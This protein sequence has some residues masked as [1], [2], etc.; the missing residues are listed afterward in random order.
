[1]SAIVESVVGLLSARSA[2]AREQMQ[3]VRGWIASCVAAMH[4]VNAARAAADDVRQAKMQECDTTIAA[5]PAELA[6]LADSVRDRDHARVSAIVDDLNASAGDA[7]AKLLDKTA[8]PDMTKEIDRFQRAAADLAGLDRASSFR[9][10]AWQ[11]AKL[12]LITIPVVSAYL[13]G[14]YFRLRDRVDLQLETLSSPLLAYDASGGGYAMRPDW[15]KRFFDEF[16][17][18][19]FGRDNAMPADWKTVQL[20]FMFRNPRHGAPLMI[21]TI[22]ATSTYHASPFPWQRVDDTPNV[23][24]KRDR[25]NIVLADESGV[26]APVNVRANISAA[27][28]T[29]DQFETPSF[30]SSRHSFSFIFDESAA[31]RVKIGNDGLI[32]T[33]YRRADNEPPPADAVTCNGHTF[34]QIRTFARLREVTPVAYQTDTTVAYSYES[35]R[36]RKFA[37]TF[38]TPLPANIAYFAPHDGLFTNDPCQEIITPTASL[39]RLPSESV[40]QI[41]DALVPQGAVDPKGVDLIIKNGAL[42]LAHAADGSRQSFMIHPDQILNAGGYLIVYVDVADLRNGSIDLSLKL[43]NDEARRVTI[44]LLAPDALRFDSANLDR[45]RARFAS[46]K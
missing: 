9:G 32:S 29:L 14:S 1:M 30:L 19:Y 40:S 34:E 26:G 21:S 36:G 38:S 13:A 17:R 43:N 44:P 35:L 18:A 42:S 23:T 4:E 31:H 10:F 6:T 7:R 5:A 2:P 11:F 27:G 3:R 39:E 20:K 33:I 12:I 24:A 15:E 25:D 8:S 37:S 22:E 16:S 28:I 46:A 45:E 41:A